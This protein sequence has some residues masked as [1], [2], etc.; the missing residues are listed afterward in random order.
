M[1]IIPI[2]NLSNLFAFNICNL[3][4]G[5]KSAHKNL[6]VSVNS[7]VVAFLVFEFHKMTVLKC[8]KNV[9]NNINF[10]FLL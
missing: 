7:E 3:N 5:H 9:P 8:F 4:Q 2:D 6:R 1:L 10:Y